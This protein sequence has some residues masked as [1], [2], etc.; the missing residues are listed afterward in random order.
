MEVFE[1]EGNI[2]TIFESSISLTTPV[3]HQVYKEGMSYEGY[4]LPLCREKNSTTVIPTFIDQ[5][6]W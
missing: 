4:Q 3:T 2:L 1:S 6:L 5:K